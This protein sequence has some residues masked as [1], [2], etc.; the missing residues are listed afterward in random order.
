MTL[1]YSA[2]WLLLIA[3]APLIIL[4]ALHLRRTALRLPPAGGER[5]GRIA[6]NGKPLRLLV[7]G[8]ST[9]AGVGAESH[10]EALS[11]RLAAALHRQTGKSIAWEAAGLNG[12]V[13]RETAAK[14]LPWVENR[15]VDVLVL[16]LGVNDVLALRSPRAWIADL[17]R[18]LNRLHEE[19]QPALTVISAVPPVGDFPAIPRPL[20]TLFG[21]VADSLNQITNRAAADWE[22][23]CYATLPDELPRDAVHFSHDG[24]HPS[25]EGYRVWAEWLAEL[26]RDRLRG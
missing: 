7:I 22:N 4:Q 5:Q 1:R 9:V 23:V 8:E 3:L 15:P 19:L 18:L 11:G 20:R 24:F 14:L 10:D 26:V 25:P 2:A 6:G 12:M 13:A 16:A 21:L 17:S